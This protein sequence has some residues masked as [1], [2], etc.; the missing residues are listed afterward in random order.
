ML[1]LVGYQV[2]R[3]Q[4]RYLSRITGGENPESLPKQD[5]YD[6]YDADSFSKK[7]VFDMSANDTDVY[8]EYY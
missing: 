1:L 5:N 6:E 2:V 4:S 3:I 7:E 8:G